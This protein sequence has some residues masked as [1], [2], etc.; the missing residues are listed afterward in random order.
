MANLE[1]LLTQHGP[2]GLVRQVKLAAEHQL[3][4][5][6]VLCMGAIVTI[7]RVEDRI[8]AHQA[9]G[10]ESLVNVMKAFPASLIIAQGGLVALNKVWAGGLPPLDAPFV[11]TER[12]LSAILHAMVTF[13][14]DLLLQRV[15]MH[16][17][18]V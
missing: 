8:A 10:A 15:S 17:T 7:H 12:V 9:K 11:P 18:P 4:H 3:H 1:A 5:R 14:G 2:R 16:L 13:K 6:A